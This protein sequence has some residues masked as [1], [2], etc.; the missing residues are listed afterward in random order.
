[1]NIMN[2]VTL[3]GLLM[4]KTRTIVTIIGVI[5]STSMLTAV[6]TL[7]SSLQEYIIEYTIA[8]KGDWHG[9]FNNIDMEDY[10]AL[11]ENDNIDTIA[12]THL[13]G[14]SMLE[15]S[16]N[17]NK[18]FLRVLEF[19]EKAFETIP[20][21]LVS[22]RL[23]QDD[24]EVLLSEHIYTNGGVKIN[25]GDKLTLDMGDRVLDDGTVVTDINGY[26]IGENDEIIETI[27]INESRVYTVVGVSKR[28]DY[29]FENYSDPDIP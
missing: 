19:D 1:M 21:K 5:L 25:I 28:L 9:A 29:Q 6:T 26:I 18:P 16:I 15:G 10:R 12:V 4:N 11:K 23:P 17:K 14:Y 7:I 24:T 2:K 22:G 3:K 20:V 27:R 13:A 8:D